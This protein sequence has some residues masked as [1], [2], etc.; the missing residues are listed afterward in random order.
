MTRPS[1]LRAASPSRLRAS[2]PPSRAD[3]PPRQVP[4]RRWR[5]TARTIPRG[6]SRDPRR[7]PRRRRRPP[8]APWPAMAGGACRAGVQVQPAAPALLRPRRHGHRRRPRPSRARARQSRSRPRDRGRLVGRPP[9]HALRR[10][11]PWLPSRS[12]ASPSGSRDEPAPRV[13][14]AGCGSAP[15]PWAGATAAAR[16]PATSRPR[17]GWAAGPHGGGG[18]P[19]GAGCP[20]VASPGRCPSA[21]A[22]PRRPRRPPPRDRGPSLPPGTRHSVVRGSPGRPSACSPPPTAPVAERRLRRRAGSGTSVPSRSAG[23]RSPRG[24]LAGRPGLRPPPGPQAGRVPRLPRDSTSPPPVRVASPSPAPPPAAP[25]REASPS[26]A[27]GSASVGRSPSLTRAALPC[28]RTTPAGR[29]ATRCSQ[30]RLPPPSLVAPGRPPSG[31]RPAP[32]CG[33]R[34][35]RS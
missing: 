24:E 16:R 18:H 26:R 33:A 29:P 31:S 9:R 8:I 17:A 25:V 3:R 27:T 22:R 7:T 14:A 13:G 1:H 20:A 10:P 34:R 35:N 2:A 28:R 4:A 6:R 30:R 12:P 19:G 23:R 11:A 32:R 21:L 15:P 5:P